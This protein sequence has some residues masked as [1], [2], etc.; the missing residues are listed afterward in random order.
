M[1]FFFFIFSFFFR[2]IN[3]NLVIVNLLPIECQQKL[4]ICRP[5]SWG[6]YSIHFKILSCKMIRYLLLSLF[7]RHFIGMV[8]AI[9]VV[10]CSPF[11][12]FTMISYEV[13]K[14]FVQVYYFQ[15]KIQKQQTLMCFRVNV[16]CLSVAISQWHNAYIHIYPTYFQLRW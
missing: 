10:R 7:L 5:C 1:I 12:L 2:D 8:V 15:I 11:A 6:T 4:C 14:V 13:W 9:H 16:E 3:L